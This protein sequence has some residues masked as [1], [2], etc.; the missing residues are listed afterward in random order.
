MS[1][2]TS[3]R[4]TSSLQYVETARYLAMRILGFC[5]RFPKRL[6]MRLT[7]P[8]CNHATEALYHVQAANRVYVR[9]DADAQRRRGHLQEALGHID[10]VAT[11]LDIC[12]ELQAVD[13]S[14][15]NP[16]DNVYEQLANL[17]DRERH[18]IGGV[19]RKDRDA[20]G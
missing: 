13:D 7:N 6:A 16:N 5:N 11:L 3:E 17:I 15:K 4:R 20:R 8:L 19:M 1:V 14:L 10:H 2:P 12:Y 9:S 18:L